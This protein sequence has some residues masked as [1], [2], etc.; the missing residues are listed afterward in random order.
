MVVHHTFYW[1][2]YNAAAS[3]PGGMAIP[4]ILSEPP[5]RGR[6]F[7]SVFSEREFK[8]VERL[9]LIGRRNG[10]HQLKAYRI[11]TLRTPGEPIAPE[12]HD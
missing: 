12:K 7:W 2:D 6:R 5:L 4:A 11:K 1:D 10:K 8:Y 9:V 3:F